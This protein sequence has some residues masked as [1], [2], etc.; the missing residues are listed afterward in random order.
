MTEPRDFFNVVD[1]WQIA[2]DPSNSAR[3]PLRAD[4]V[5]NEGNAVRPMLPYYLLMR[6]PED[7]ELSFLIMQ[8]FTPANRPNMVSFMVAKSGP[9]DYGEIVEYRLPSS[10]A[11][12]GPGQVGQFINQDTAIAAEF[13]LLSQGGSDIIQG[14]ML[15]VPVEES[16]LYVQPIY[17]T[18]DTEGGAEGIPEFKRAVVSF[19]GQIEMRESLDEALAA[20]FVAAPGGEDPP[21]DGEEP[22]P[23]DP[24]AVPAEVASLLAAA[25]VAF[26]DAQTALAGGDLGGYQSKVDD[27]A[28]LVGRAIALGGVTTTTTT[29]APPATTAPPTTAATEG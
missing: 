20:I 4:F 12:Q 16:L 10:T 24:E 21:V 5:D 1:P 7:E 23:T 29:T 3:A 9:E 22:P 11:Q 17:I 26:E 13:T 6:L 14:N 25:A 27:A 18:A 2:S 28:R 15:V 19:N 8:P